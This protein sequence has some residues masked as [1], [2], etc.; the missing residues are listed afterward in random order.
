MV[1]SRV[2]AVQPLESVTRR[3]RVIRNSFRLPCSN[4]EDSDDDVLSVGAVWPAECCSTGWGGDGRC[5]S[6]TF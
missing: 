5:S 2:G 3:S 4:S 1:A 6:A